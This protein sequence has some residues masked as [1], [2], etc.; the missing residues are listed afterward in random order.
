MKDLFKP[1]SLAAL[2]FVGAWAS[3]AD[4]YTPTRNAKDQG[5][6]LKSWGSGTIAETSEAAFDG[7]QSIRIASRNFFQG[8]LMNYATPVDLSSEFGDRNNLLRLMVNVP[9]FTG[10]TGASTGAAAI[11]M[12]RFVITTS[13]GKKS[14]AY[15]SLVTTTA[16][17]RGWRGIGIPLQAIR[18]FGDTNKQV[19][20]I[21][22]SADAVGTVYIG[23]MR[24]INDA[25]P[26]YGE[27]GVTELNLAINDEYTF[28]ASGTGGATPLRFTWDFDAS[29]GIDV[30]ADGQSV[31]RRFRKPGEYTIT[32]TVVDIYGLKQPH[33]STVKVTVNP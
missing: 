18:G 6:T 2:S 23:E 22:L 8:G 11:K 7:T 32:L 17:A 29:D 30:D 21:A 13:D 25:T 28:T 26:V 16:D 5:I 33:T 27:T 3:A 31:K 1:L 4:L 14:E 20:S 15:V 19:S 10:S 12:L 24:T 9:G